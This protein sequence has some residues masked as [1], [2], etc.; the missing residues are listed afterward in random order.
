MSDRVHIKFDFINELGGI[1]SSVKTDG[2]YYSETSVLTYKPTRCEDPE[3]SHLQSCMNYSCLQM[4]GRGS[5]K[6]VVEPSL[7]SKVRK[8]RT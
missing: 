4:E 3:K 2:S 6:E 8:K 5:E 1:N 7:A